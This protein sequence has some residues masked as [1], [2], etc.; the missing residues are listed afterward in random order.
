MLCLVQFGH[1]ASAVQAVV[2][3]CVLRVVCVVQHVIQLARAKGIKTVNVIRARWV[4]GQLGHTMYAAGR[5]EPLLPR[6][7]CLLMLCRAHS[8]LL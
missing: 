3:V 2:C 4:Q 6:A 1:K 7:S 8:C 5:T